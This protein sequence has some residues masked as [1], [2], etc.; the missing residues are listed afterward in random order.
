MEP[1]VAVLPPPA[2]GEDQRAVG[3][4]LFGMGPG[5]F[6]GFFWYRFQ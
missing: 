1:Q 6:L 2:G 3:I 5:N 4:G